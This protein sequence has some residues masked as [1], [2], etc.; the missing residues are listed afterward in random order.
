MAQ[1]TEPQTILRQVPGTPIDSFRSGLRNPSDTTQARI[2]TRRGY[3]MHRLSCTSSWLDRKRTVNEPMRAAFAIGSVLLLAACHHHHHSDSPPAPTP[4]VPAPTLSSISPDHATA[5]GAAFTLTVN[6]SDFVSSSSVT[7]NGAS[8]TTTFVS[9][10]QLTI[11]VGTADIQNAASVPIAVTTPA[12][13]G[14]T[15]SPLT[16]TIV[17]PNPAPAISSLAPSSATAGGPAFT[18]TVNGTGFLSSSTVAWN[19]SN[20]P[21]T[22]VSAAQLTASI[23]AAD[24]QS[25]G[26]TPIT[27]TNPV[28]GGGISAAV[29]FTTTAPPPKAGIVKALATNGRGGALTAD[30]RYA[31]FQSDDGSIVANDMNNFNDVFLQDACVGP[32][33]P[34][35]CNTVTTRQ[36]LRADG[37]ELAGG[38]NVANRTTRNVSDDGRFVVFDARIGDLVSSPSIPATIHEVFL[39]DTCT[40]QPASCVPSVTMVSVDGTGSPASL[41]AFVASISG[42]GRVV[43]FQSTAPNL[44]GSAAFR[45]GVYAYDTCFGAI[46]PC[47]PGVLQVSAGLTGA[48]TSSG[49]PAIDHSGRYV[50]FET[51]GST[52]IVTHH[53]VDVVVRDTCIGAPTSPGCTPSTQLVSAPLSTLAADTSNFAD[54]AA[55]S[56][57]GRYVLFE[58]ALKDL[59]AT[60]TK[61]VMQVYMRDTCL[62]ASGSCTPATQLVSVDPAGTAAGDLPS[63]L[64]SSGVVSATGRFVVFSSEAGNLVAGA[65]SLSGNTEAYARDTCAGVATGCTPRTVA[66]SVDAQG[67][68][69][70]T[71]GASFD[72]DGISADGHYAVIF[73]NTGASELDLALTGF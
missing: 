26:T 34:A 12:P 30:G 17:A 61:D 56:G 39:R 67:N 33:A 35:R 22:F 3:C 60:N 1:A 19:G 64:H 38:A 43:T 25:A 13:G 51:T 18:L 71:G 68:F 62:G 37:G 28:P 55:I 27:V 58:A 24:I 69:I 16:L 29:T 5:G 10:T 23:P 15:S 6:G 9:G 72:A 49:R 53:L 40:G 70:T 32:G 63:Y 46:Q 31:T 20:R 54:F 65:A 45:T 36:S 21:T 41:D 52:G 11:A 42:N 14:G 66:I 2:R 73:G 57:D 47:T 44:P 8:R 48:S 4:T 7:W 50:A 59:L